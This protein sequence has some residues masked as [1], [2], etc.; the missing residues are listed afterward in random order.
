MNEKQERA[1]MP[2]GSGKF[3]CPSKRVVG[4]MLI[5][6]MVATLVKCL[7]DSCVVVGEDDERF[8]FGEGLLESGR[9]AY[10]GL[11]LLKFKKP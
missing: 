9:E 8:D 6:I 7:G 10:E 4:P 3:V 5:G 2:F 1:F 11:G